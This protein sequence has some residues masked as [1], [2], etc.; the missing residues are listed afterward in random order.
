[1]PDE[2]VRSRAAVESREVARERVQRGFEPLVGD[3]A[4]EAEPLREPRRADADAELLL[5]A[6]AVPERELRAAAARVEHDERAGHV[7]ERGLDREV[8]DPRLL[9][10][11][12]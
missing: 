4:V 11:R 9:V 10:A 7:A 5:D 8:G 1:Q 12:D 2:L 6:P 3:D